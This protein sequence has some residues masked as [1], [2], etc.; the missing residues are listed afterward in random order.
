MVAAVIAILRI[1]V[2]FNN[3][4]KNRKSKVSAGLIVNEEKSPV[5]EVDKTPAVI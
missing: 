1:I 2:W 5:D 4:R 3:R